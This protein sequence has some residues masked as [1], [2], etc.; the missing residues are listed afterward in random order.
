MKYAFKIW[1]WKG[2]RE[3]R[4]KA[5]N[6]SSPADARNKGPF[7]DD[8]GEPVFWVNWSKPT[9]P[10]NKSRPAHFSHYPKS[11]VK[12]K[13][14]KDVA[15]EFNNYKPSESALHEKARIALTSYLDERIEKGEN[16][17]WYFKDDSVSDYSLN[18]NLLAN[19]ESVETHYIYQTNFEISFEYDIAILGPKIGKER[20][21]LAVIELEKSHMFGFR[22][23]LISKCLGFPLIS[24]S[25]DSLDIDEINVKWCSK[26]LRET[27][28][29]SIDSLRRNYIYLHKSLYPIY[30]DIPK[31]YRKKNKHHFIVFSEYKSLNNIEN[32]L[33][34]FKDRLGLSN[35]EVSITPVNFNPDEQTSISMFNN[36]G[37]IAGKSWDTINCSTFIRISTQIPN[38]KIGNLYLF[39]LVLSRL[40]NAHFECLIGYK[41]SNGMKNTNPDVNYWYSTYLKKKIAPKSISE[42]IRPII[43][44]LNRYGFS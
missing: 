3:E 9:G 28:T 11:E 36:E 6:I 20:L 17:N 38:P 16:I 4:V 26:I 29:N 8:K 30:L 10:N 40:L 37:S 42:P 5:T 24:I 31:D 14:N 41:P 7:V 15:S 33:N 44:Y 32:I 12:K 23:K 43:N 34:R 25:L 13:L 21:I 35:K 22:K 27:T 1:S 39:H 18:G 19:A 2:E